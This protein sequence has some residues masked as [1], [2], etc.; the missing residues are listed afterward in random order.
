[1]PKSRN[2]K[3]RRPHKTAEEMKLEPSWAEGIS[4][5]PSWWAPV[6]IALL[7]IGLIWVVITYMFN[8]AYPVPRIGNWNIGI[9][10]GI[11][12]VGFLMTLRWR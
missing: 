6:F 7:I 3:D 12:F 2:R 8:A 1:M 10:L 4:P 11:M 5:S 9:G